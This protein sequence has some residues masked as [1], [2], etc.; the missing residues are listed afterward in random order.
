MRQIDFINTFFNI[1]FQN[2]SAYMRDFLSSYDYIVHFR[3]WLH[4]K[5]I[6]WTCIESIDENLYTLLSKKSQSN[7]G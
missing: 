2:E 5:G 7:R 1:L 3:E 6:D 4:S